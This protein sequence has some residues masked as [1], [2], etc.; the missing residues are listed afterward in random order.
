V[1]MDARAHKTIYDGCDVA[2]GHG[3]TVQRFRH[4]DPEDLERLLRTSRSS[5]RVICMDGVNSMTGNAPAMREFARIARHYDALLYVDDAQG[6]GILGERSS[7]ELCGYGTKGNGLVRHAGETYDNIVMVAGLSKAYSSLTAFVACPARLKEILKTA[8]P[9]YLYSQPSPVASLATTLEGLKVNE[10]RGD[11][12]RLIVYRKTQRLLAALHELG[13]PTSNRSG[14][15][16]VGLP[17]ASAGDLKE[18]GLEFFGRGVYL[19]LAAHPLV[20]HEESGFR[21]QL[22]AAHS[23]EQIEHLVEVLGELAGAFRGTERRQPLR[24]LKRA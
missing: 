16:I 6:F 1:F 14:H 9:P 11:L 23:D 5:P 3:A 8:A 15:P 13:I 17:L 18:V 2:R 20:P 19:T 10:R 7:M 24:L 22:T 21:I 4:Q 12:L